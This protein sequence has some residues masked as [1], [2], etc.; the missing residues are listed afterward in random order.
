[1]LIHEYL[2]WQPKLVN[3]SEKG[4]YDDEYA[5]WILRNRGMNEYKSYIASF[6]PTEPET[7]IPKLQIF[8]GA[9]PI[10]VE[11]IK[12]CSYDKPKNNKPAEDIAEFEG[13]DPIDGLRYLVDAAEGFFDE[14]NEEFKRI[15][16]ED[17]LVQRLNNTQDWTAFYRN[18]SKVESSSEDRI[19]P[20]SRYR[21]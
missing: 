7:N 2:R 4:V 12:A 1:M 6:N 3:E 18:M 8:S 10:L 11:A 9:C 16:V 5:M 17:Q 15:Q 14:S 20:V 19:K 21:H 13:D